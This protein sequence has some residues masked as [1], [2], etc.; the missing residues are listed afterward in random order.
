MQTKKY[1]CSGTLNSNRVEE[2]KKKL[3]MVKFMQLNFIQP[4]NIMFMIDF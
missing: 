1:C 3:I 2:K 4:L